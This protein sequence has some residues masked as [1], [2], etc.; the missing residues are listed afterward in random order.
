MNSIWDPLLVAVLSV[1][2]IASIGLRGR[3]LG[4]RRTLVAAERL[5][6][7][8]RPGIDQGWSMGEWD[9]AIKKVLDDKAREQA[10][11]E[12]DGTRYT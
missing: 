5:L 7:A 2:A 12:D 11:M 9:W 3:V 8:R 4:R 6:R 10:V 1:L